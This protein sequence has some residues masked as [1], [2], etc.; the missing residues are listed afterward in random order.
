[1]FKDTR[2]KYILM[3]KYMQMYMLKFLFKYMFEFVQIY[4]QGYWISHIIEMVMLCM[5]A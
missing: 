5:K 4:A 2:Q 1:M 3:I